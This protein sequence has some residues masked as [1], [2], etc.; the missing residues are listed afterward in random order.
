VNKNE[1]EEHPMRRLA[2]YLFTLCSMVSLLLCVVACVLWA[3]SCFA[4]DEFLQVA[5]NGST[6]RHSQRT[7]AWERGRLFVSYRSMDLPP[8]RTYTQFRLPAPMWR[9][10]VIRKSTGDYEFR[11]W[12]AEFSGAGVGRGAVNLT[13]D[14]SYQVAIVLWPVIPLTAVLPLLWLRRVRRDRRAREM[15]SG[16]CPACGYDLRASP[17]RCPEC[18]APASPAAAVSSVKQAAA[19]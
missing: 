8:G 7:V 16:L 9:H 19:P 6:G 1:F 11:W 13:W 3:R 17:G 15:G 18:G 2:R 4:F 10:R 12:Q 14:R 5:W